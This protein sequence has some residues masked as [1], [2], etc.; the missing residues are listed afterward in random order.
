VTLRF[1]HLRE[2]LARRF[3]KNAASSEQPFHVFLSRL[4]RVIQR[5][6]AKLLLSIHVRSL[7][8]EQLRYFSIP[9]PGSRVQR[10]LSGNIFGIDVRPFSISSSTISLFSLKAA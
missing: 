9:L 1:S 5:C 2:L 8:H 4:D 7:I 3:S 10:R 6:P